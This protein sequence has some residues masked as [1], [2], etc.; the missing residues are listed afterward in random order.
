MA[1]SFAVLT[2][3]AMSFR[4]C[5]HTVEEHLEQIDRHGLDVLAVHEP[6]VPGGSEAG[7]P[8]STR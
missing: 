1:A 4:Y 6:C 8:S 7:R 3:G 2:A 5:A